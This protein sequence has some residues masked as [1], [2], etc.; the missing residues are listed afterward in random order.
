[1]YFF[2]ST[3]CVWEN[4]TFIHYQYKIAQLNPGILRLSREKRRF[5]D[6]FPLIMKNIKKI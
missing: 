6:A 4:A 5:Y 1:M 2:P 3:E